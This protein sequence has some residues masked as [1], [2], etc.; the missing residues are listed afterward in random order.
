MKTIQ[1]YILIDPRTD[2]IRYVGKTEQTLSARLNAHMQ[3]KGKCHR[4]NWLNE[5]KALGL[6]PRVVTLVTIDLF[7]DQ[8]DKIWQSEERYW[9]KRLK[10]M[11]A[12]LTNNTI[13]GDGVCGL[14][15]EIRAKMRLTWLGRK[16]K[17]ETIE[18]LK[19]ARAKRVMTDETKKKMSA[20]QKGRKI[21]WID[22]IAK[23]NRKIDEK[24]AMEIETRIKQ[25]EKVT[26][27]AR[28]LGI[29]RT[30][31]SKIKAGT[32]FI[33]YREFV[34]KRKNA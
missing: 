22:A 6:K 23:A 5:L 11:G 12:R 20:S 27:I 8:G 17:P 34:A 16:H 32:Y 24:T 26:D 10:S 14:P 7:D 29:H 9:I 33:P 19:I 3:D 18:K 25:G 30:T 31:I 1:I 21:T 2:E 28:E 4:V 13:G 15:P